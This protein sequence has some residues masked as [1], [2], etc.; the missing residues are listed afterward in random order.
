LCSGR[1]APSPVFRWR[2]RRPQFWSA[3]PAALAIAA[4]NYVWVLQADASFEEASAQQAE[5]VV[6]RLESRVLRRE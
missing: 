3:L 6:A 1:S 4:A 5:Q 2:K